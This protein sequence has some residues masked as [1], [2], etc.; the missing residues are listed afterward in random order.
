MMTSYQVQVEFLLGFSKYKSINPKLGLI[1][2]FSLFPYSSISN[3]SASPAVSTLKT[4]P[5]SIH[6]PSHLHYCQPN[7][8]RHN[9]SS[10]LRQQFPLLPY[11]SPF[12]IQKPSKNLSSIM[13]TLLKTPWLPYTLQIKSKCLYQSKS[14]L[15]NFVSYNLFPY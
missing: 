1:I 14:Y 2:Y 4:H 13:T 11:H 12:A 6:F 3:W 10:G 9:L 5:G 15:S 8:G 7:P